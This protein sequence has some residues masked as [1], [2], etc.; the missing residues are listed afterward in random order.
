[1]IEVSP[2]NNSQ[3]SPPAVKKSNNSL[4][5]SPEKKKAEIQQFNKSTM[6]VVGEVSG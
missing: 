2:H 3:N 4:P 5:N 1:V 6:E